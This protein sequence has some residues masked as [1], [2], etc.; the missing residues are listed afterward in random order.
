MSKAAMGMLTQAYALELGP[1]GVRVKAIA[2]GLIQKVISVCYRKDEKMKSKI[3]SQQ[4]I[5]HLGQPTE[6][7]ELAVLLASDGASYMTGQT[8]VVDGGA[9]LV[10][11][12]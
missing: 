9:T 2:P 7:A 4:P 5:Q 3:V 10:G 6:V 11:R 12:L 1:K 8:V